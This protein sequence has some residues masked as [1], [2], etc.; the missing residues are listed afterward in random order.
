MHH[1]GFLQLLHKTLHRFKSPHERRRR[2]HQLLR[3]LMWQLAL[4]LCWSTLIMKK[5][6][7][8]HTSG[9]GYIFHTICI[10]ILLHF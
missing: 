1:P 9:K 8:N 6:Q 7:P 5:I 2:Q 4:L 3:Y 10:K